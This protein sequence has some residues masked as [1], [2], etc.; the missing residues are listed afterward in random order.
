MSSST[1]NLFLHTCQWSFFT[2]IIYINS[3]SQS[4]CQNGRNPIS[5][6]MKPLFFIHPKFMNWARVG[7][8]RA[9][10]ARTKHGHGIG[11]GR[12]GHGLGTGTGMGGLGTDWARAGWARSD[13]VRTSRVPTSEERRRTSSLILDE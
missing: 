9:D 3:V 10:W 5:S 8:A 6:K 4:V 7:T 11:H 12:T 13:C 1:T 2:H